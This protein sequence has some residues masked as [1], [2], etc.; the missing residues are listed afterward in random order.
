MSDP[1]FLPEPTAQELLTQLRHMLAQHGPDRQ[2]TALA[3]PPAAASLSSTQER[4]LTRQRVLED[5]LR[6]LLQPMIQRW[7]DQKLESLVSRVVREEMAQTTRVSDEAQ[8]ESFATMIVSLIL[9]K[10]RRGG[11]GDRRCS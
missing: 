11:V 8:Y 10:K 3:A 1:N 4:Q 5:L 7:L 6:E 2:P 9:R